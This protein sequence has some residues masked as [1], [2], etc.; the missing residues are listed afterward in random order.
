MKEGVKMEKKI[1]I[2]YDI[3]TRKLK[4]DENDFTTFEALG[5]LEAA[6]AMISNNWLTEE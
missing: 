1:L 3:I 4:I 5:I 2:K 6:K